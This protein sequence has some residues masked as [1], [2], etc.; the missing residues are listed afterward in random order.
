MQKTLHATHFPKWLDKM[1]TYEMD[2]TKTV[3]ATERTRNAGRTDGRGETNIPPTT[4]LC[5]GYNY[6]IDCNDN[7]K[8]Y[9]DAGGLPVFD[10]AFN[11]VVTNF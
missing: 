6:H 11:V 1:Y 2:P 4:S 3:G 10:N 9:D 7:C 5:V 8:W